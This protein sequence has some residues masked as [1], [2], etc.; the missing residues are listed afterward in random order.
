MKGLRRFFKKLSNT[1]TRREQRERLQEEMETHLALLSEEMMRAGYSQEEARRRARIKFGGT[2]AA[3]E[4]YEA[5][6][7]WLAVEWL[8]Q[9][10]RFGLRMLRKSPA[11]T[12]V[13]VLTLALGIGANTAI[14]SLVDAVRA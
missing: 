5:E 12:A 8:L 9:D 13:A 7:R 2:E 6:R 14:F 11:F 3:R 10:V 1:A 4:N